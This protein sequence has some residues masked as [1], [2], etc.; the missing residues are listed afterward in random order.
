M[1]K[2]YTHEQ[3][4]E[5]VYNKHSWIKKVVGTYVNSRTS[6][7]IECV[8]GH[9]HSYD[10]KSLTKTDGIKGCPVCKELK[11]S[12]TQEQYEANPK[13]CE[14]CNQPIPFNKSAAYTRAKR[15]CSVQCANKVN[16]QLKRKEDNHCLNCGK[17][18]KN[19]KYCSITC[20]KEYENKLKVQ[21]WLNNEWDGTMANGVLSKAIRHYLLK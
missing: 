17:E 13:L 8:N 20:Q 5:I 9:I 21:Q 19:T 2:T 6:I 11:Y 10:P 3:F 14:Y 12:E 7:E 18:T 4:C 15:F 1:P 16:N